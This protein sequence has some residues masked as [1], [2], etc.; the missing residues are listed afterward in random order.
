MIH[1]TYTCRGETSPG[2]DC[3]NEF[4]V[5]IHPGAP[6]RMHGHPDDWCPADDDD[7]QPMECPICGA[8]VDEDWVAQ[9]I[10]EARYE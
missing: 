4:D 9:N 1:A 5:T 7:V 3:E 2:F 10:K 6:A 8:E